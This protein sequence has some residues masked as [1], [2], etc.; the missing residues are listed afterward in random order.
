MGPHNDSFFDP[1]GELV[2]DGHTVGGDIVD[3]DRHVPVTQESPVTRLMVMG[4]TEPVGTLLPA[5]QH[6]L[7]ARELAVFD[8]LFL[9]KSKA[10]STAELLFE[11]FMRLG[12]TFEP[13]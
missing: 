12:L 7:R 13:C 8:Q 9:D 3:S 6:D 11:G 4:V 10:T 1:L 5:S 2:V